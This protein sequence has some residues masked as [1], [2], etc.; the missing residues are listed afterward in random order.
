M[1]TPCLRCTHPHEAHS[2]YRRGTECS[3]CDC[4]AFVPPS[5]GRRLWR[6]LRPHGPVEW[7]AV[8]LILILTGL[9]PVWYVRNEAFG[10]CLGASKSYARAEVC[11]GTIQPGR[12]AQASKG[13][14]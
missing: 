9:V 11:A 2:H 12:P 5:P 13:K 14:P 10:H 8:V 7:A 1:N 6:W 3:L 4:P